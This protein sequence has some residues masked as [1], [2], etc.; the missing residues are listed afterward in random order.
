MTSELDRDEPHGIEVAASLGILMRPFQVEFLADVANRTDIP[1][2]WFPLAITAVGC[3]SHCG[4][5]NARMAD[6]F[7]CDHC[8]DPHVYTNE[9][10]EVAPSGQLTVHDPLSLRELDEA[11]H[12]DCEVCGSCNTYDADIATAH[13]RTGGFPL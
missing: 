12:L 5:C 2:K 3:R 7:F 4:A 11:L 10:L 13:F 1:A 8:G 6:V 9:Q